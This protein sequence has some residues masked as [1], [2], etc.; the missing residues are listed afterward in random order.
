MADPTGWEV[1]AY[2]QATTSEN[3]IHDD[4]IARK[5]GFRGGLVPGVTVYAYMVQPAIVSWGLDWLSRG[6]ANVVLRK[7][8]YEGD[9][10]RVECKADGSA[11][12]QGEV[13]DPEDSVCAMGRVWL[14]DSLPEPPT[15]RGDPRAPALEDRPEGTRS[16]LERLRESGL[17]SLRLEWQG[18]PP[19]DRYTQTIDEMADLV[20]HDAGGFAHPGFTL[21]LANLMLTVNVTLGPWIHVQS[22]I[23]HFAP[24]PL[25]STLHVEAEVTDLFERRGHEFIDL[26]VAAFLDPDQPALRATHR[27]IYQL[28]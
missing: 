17:G 28:R 9:R 16:T 12:Y 24:V 20:R 5:Y 25:G 13:I 19:Y 4:T 26:D 1:V 3:K 7:P 2:N 6:A 18:S 14:P 22:E 8:V 11:A 23:Q 21:G 15:R 10:A 27:A